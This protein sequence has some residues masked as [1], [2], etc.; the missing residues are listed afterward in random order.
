LKAAA[1][2]LDSALTDQAI[3]QLE[4][5]YVHNLPESLN[6]RQELARVKDTAAALL[7]KNY[8]NANVESISVQEVGRNTLDQYY[9]S[10]QVPVLV[11]DKFTIPVAGG[12]KVSGDRWEA[13]TTSIQVKLLYDLYHKYKSELFSANVRGYLG[14]RRSD[15][16]INNNIKQTAK[17]A[18]QR[19]WA[20][21]N[22]ITALVNDLQVEGEKDQQT[23]TIHGIAIVNGA[24]TTGSIGSLEAPSD[25]RVLAR[26]VKCSDS[27]VI[28]DIIQFNNSQNKVEA[29]DFRSNDVIQNRLRREFAELPD[30]LYLGG[31][32]GTDTDKI[33]RPSNLIPTDT[34]AQALVAFHQD[35]NL[36][37]NEKRQIWESDA[38]YARFFSSHTTARHLLLCFSLLRAIEHMKQELQRI[39]E[40][41]RTQQQKIQVEF[42]RERGATFLLVS[43]VA[44]CIEIYA[45][46]AIADRFQVRFKKDFDTEKAVA[47]WL[48]VVKASLSFCKQLMSALDKSLKNSA[49]VKAALEQFTGLIEATEQAN[50]ALF[51]SFRDT[52]DL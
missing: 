16:N 17:E 38:H 24:Q 40:E 20:Y 31:R 1:K 4:I 52:L 21:N 34:T 10:T 43:A 33:K 11:T 9:H 39:P 48:P 15:R 18:P 26:F 49:D 47:S 5:W 19:F 36:A 23:L 44:K 46:R 27:E 30:M 8:A 41:Q 12:F 42:F 25:A 51:A 2:E 28:R 35:P 6:V 50:Q 14:S 22:G 45:G 13:F 32:R 7:A 3:S 37:Y 29:T